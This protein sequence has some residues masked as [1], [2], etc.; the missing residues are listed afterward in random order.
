MAS[1]DYYRKV[2]KDRDEN[3]K[4]RLE[5]R[6]RCKTDA[7]VR[8]AVES[9]CRDDV[10]YF[11]NAMCWLYEPRPMFVEVA[12][13]RRKLPMVIPFITWPHQDTAIREIYE[14]LGLEDVGV[15]KSRGEGMSWMAILMALHDWLFVDN[16]KIGLVSRTES[17]A[18]DPEDSDSLFW[19][20]LD[21]DTPVATPLGWMPIRSIKPGDTVIG[22]NGLPISVLAA[23]Q[24]SRKECYRLTFDDGQSVVCSNDH[25]WP[26]NNFGDR[27][28]GGRYKSKSHERYY[29]VSTEQIAKSVSATAAGRVRPNW[30]VSPSPVIQYCKSS[31]AIDPYVLGVLLG[32][33]C[34]TKTGI[35]FAS[36]D[37][38]I[39]KQV[40][41]HLPVGYKVTKGHGVVWFI[42]NGSRGH[43]IPNEISRELIRLG[44]RNKTAFYKTIP[45]SYR[46]ASIGQRVALIQGLMDTD[47]TVTNTGSPYLSTT[48]S[49]MAEQFREVVL[50]LGGTARVKNY[51]KKNGTIEYR[52]N[53]SL[54]N[55]W[56]PFR[57]RRKAV[58]VKS[59]KQTTA[60]RIVA[61][62]RVGVRDVKCI[63]VDSGD[64]LFVTA[65]CLLT[66]N[67]D[68]ELT[69]LPPWMAGKRG[70]DWKRNVTNHTLTNHRNGARI[71]AGAATGD[72]F[73]GGRLTWALMDEFAFF[74]KGE[75]A[76]ALNSSHGATNSRLFVSTV[77][78][79]NNEYFRIMHEPSSMVKVIIDWKQNIARNRG[80]YQFQGGVPVA[81]DPVN[82]PLPAYYDPPTQDVLDLFARLRRKG[83]RLEGD[84]RSGEMGDDAP[85]RS[86]WYDHECDRP[87]MTPQ[88]IAQELDR[89]YAGSEYLVF[90]NEFNSHVSKQI[91]P[92]VHV[93]KFDVYEETGDGEIDYSVLFNSTF[94]GNVKL[95]MPLDVRGRPPK[96]SYALGADVC[97]GLG[98]SYTS[99]STLVGIDLLTREQVLAFASNTIE[100]GDF[101]DLA[102]GIANWLWGAYLGWE[103]NGP[104]AAFTKRIIKLAY[105]NVFRRKSQT[106]KSKRETKELGWWTD[107]KTKAA[108]FSEISRAV[109]KGD[110]VV[111]D[112]QLAKEFKQYVYLNG[113]IEHAASLTTEDSSSRGKAHGD[114]VIAFG[115][116]LQCAADRPNIAA[117]SE[118]AMRG[119]GERAR[120]SQPP[121]NTM[122][123]RMKLAEE[124]HRSGDDTDWRES[125]LESMG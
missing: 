115:V 101:A 106:K 12:G 9:A 119:Y 107:E 76:D 118:L 46:Y 52:I 90:G 32:D 21:A 14:N 29:P 62:E 60:R 73:R 113:K 93:G 25:L 110:A 92:A 10:L 121:A 47:G 123:Y 117:Q 26:V 31:Q 91:M 37:V 82:N 95:W 112:E 6:E 114:R 16:C 11:F 42:H 97:T 13:V 51:R 39:V 102:V 69:K 111:R 19:K 70:A 124:E 77:N 68:W 38:D 8:R 75:D 78:G 85:L 41:A 55:G 7:R 43:K 30:Q 105:G 40:S 64:H 57:L 104:G 50:S 23:A 109:Q 74:R 49:K 1:E 83:F 94:D 48:S 61:A 98:G 80:L 71:T 4:Y 35:E 100:P 116:V 108:M 18:D 3:L 125:V 22:S 72:V 28:N 81:V 103:H 53:I 122:A 87:G 96:S 27:S 2:P 89:D 54:P 66:H 24:V 36:I 15:E 63:S 44:I 34:L 67:C 20:C 45:D 84:H 58:L 65:G 86:P 17:A 88:R 79:Q 99:N 56:S 120:M 59:R 5:L 33:G